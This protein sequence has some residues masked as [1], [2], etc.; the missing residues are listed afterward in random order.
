MEYISGESREQKILLPDSIDDYVEGNNAVRVIE[1]YIDSLNLADLGFDKT[2]PHQTG[3]PMYN[4]KDLLKLYLYGYMNRV[5]SSRRLER[6]TKRNLEVLWLLG[7]L[8]PDHKTIARFRQEN[9]RALKNAFD[10]FVKVCV[11]LGLYGKELIAIDGSKFKAVNS[12]RRNFTKGQLQKRIEEINGK[13]A[14]YFEELD[15]NDATE[16]AGGEEKTAEA[17]AG[18]VG[19]LKKRK[20]RYERYVYELEG[21]GEKQKSQTDT[22]SRLM[23][24]NGNIDVCYNVQTAVDAKNKLVVD[25]KVTNQGNDKNF[26]TPMSVSSQKLLKKE[27]LTVVTDGGYE[28]ISDMLSATCRGVA[29]HVAGT[30]FDICIPAKEGEQVQIRSH[31]NGRCVYLAERNIALCPMGNVLYP[32]YHAKH[33]YKSDRGVFYN[34]EA[35]KQCACKCTTDARGRFQ[36]KVPMAREDF[37]KTYNDQGLAVKQIRIKADRALV[38]QRKSIV[39]HPFGTIKRA[40][41]AGYCLTKGLPNV[42]GEFSLTFLAYNLKRAINILGSKKLIESMA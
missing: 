28:S 7:R 19:E 25:F 3:R 9:S 17:I 1:A 38:K 31:H 18:I 39:E 12:R 41:D 32:A 14:A 34:Y 42:A 16:G 10:D 20:G 8:T 2:E 24:S 5:R 6:E 11:K 13:I 30:D 15:S 22:D 35:C 33:S 37:T 36:Y 21:T 4:P 29:V 26:I 27:R 40:M 23:P